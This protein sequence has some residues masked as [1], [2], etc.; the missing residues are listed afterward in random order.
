MIEIENSKY[1][2]IENYKNLL[3]KLEELKNASQKT[4]DQI[5]FLRFQVNEIQ[6][7]LSL[8]SVFR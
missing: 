3:N 5:D 6:A 7:S 2:L 8:T 4:E 1:N